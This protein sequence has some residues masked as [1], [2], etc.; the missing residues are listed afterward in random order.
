MT[1]EKDIIDIIIMVA[2]IIGAGLLVRYQVG[3]LLKNQKTMFFKLDNLAEKTTLNE[4]DLRFLKREVEDL[5]SY[6]QRI[7]ILEQTTAHHI[8]LIGAEQKFVTRREF[9]LV[10]ENMNRD[11]KE[12]KTDVKKLLKII[13][14]ELESEK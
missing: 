10:I 7:T 1:L 3:E 13:A 2:T 5:T 11:L 6:K 14:K 12:V 9:E 4:Q 8:D